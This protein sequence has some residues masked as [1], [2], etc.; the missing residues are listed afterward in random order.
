M[1]RRRWQAAPCLARHPGSTTRVTLMWHTPSTDGHPTA[2]PAARARR[3]RRRWHPAQGLRCP[4]APGTTGDVP[5]P[6]DGDSPA[7]PQPQPT[8]DRRR[9][10]PNA[11]RQAPPMAGATQERRLLAVACTPLFGPA[12]PPTP[13]LPGPCWLR[14]ARSGGT[15]RSTRTVLPLR[16]QETRWRKRVTVGAM[17]PTPP[18]GG[19]AVPSPHRRAARASRALRTGPTP[20]GL[21]R[22]GHRLR[23]RERHQRCARRAR[24]GPMARD[25]RQR[26]AGGRT[27]RRRGTAPADARRRPG[28]RP[29]TGPRHDSH[30]WATAPGHTSGGRDRA[31]P[32]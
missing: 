2:D 32:A 10:E 27:G 31:A 20:T 9:A 21:H 13:R 15:P 4:H 6:R 8:T 23:T 14:S 28:D 7:F 3:R 25:R 30:A 16:M 26:R 17:P 19:H 5:D 1:G 22:T 11:R 29:Q 18:H 24:Y 12:A